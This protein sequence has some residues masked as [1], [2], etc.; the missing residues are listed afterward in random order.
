MIW[1]LVVASAAI[2]AW[3]VLFGRAAEYDLEPPAADST[4]NPTAARRDA[5]LE[6]IRDIEFE[7]GTGKIGP[8]DYEALMSRYVADAAGAHR[9]LEKDLAATL[10][11]IESRVGRRKQE[12]SKK[13]R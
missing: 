5:A 12:L 8:A 11:S 4:E 9:E 1:V 6:A 13:K 2:V 3:P 7:H 10:S